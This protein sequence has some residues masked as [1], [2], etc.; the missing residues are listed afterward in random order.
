MTTESG[1]T[2]K[3]CDVTYNAYRGIN[4]PSRGVEDTSTTPT[5]RSKTDYP[6]L[7]VTS[8]VEASVQE[9]PFFTAKKSGGRA[10][11]LTVVVPRVKT[12]DFYSNCSF[13]R[14]HLVSSDPGRRRLR[15]TVGT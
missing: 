2:T 8:L 14:S 9:T 10:T 1:R 11:D 12:W 15:G 6:T 7:V 13:L 4:I 5:D 3:Q